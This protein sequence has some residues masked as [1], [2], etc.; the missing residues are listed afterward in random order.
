MPSGQRPAGTPIGRARR[1]C[2]R[3]STK[4]R[5][6]RNG[7]GRALRRPR[8]MSRRSGRTRRSTAGRGRPGAAQGGVAGG[9]MSWLSE[10][11]SEIRA[12]LA[13]V[14]AW[15]APCLEQARQWLT[16]P[17]EPLTWAALRAKLTLTT[18]PLPKTNGG[19]LAVLVGVGVLLLLALLWYASGQPDDKGVV[20]YPHASLINPI[21]GGLGALFLIY[22][23]IRQAGKSPLIGM[24]LKPMPISNGGPRRPSARQSSSSAARR[25][26]CGS[27]ASTR[28]SVSPGKPWPVLRGK[29]SGPDL[30]WTVMETLTAFVRERAR[31]KEPEPSAPEMAAQSDLWQSGS[32]SDQARQQP[33]TPATDIAAV[34]EVLRRRPDAGREREKLRDWRLDLTKTDLR[35][36]RLYE[37]HLE[38]ATSSRRI[39]KAPTSARRISKRADLSEA[40][41]E[42]AH[43]IGAHLERAVLI[44]AHLEGANLGG[45]HLEG[46]V[47]ESASSAG[48]SATP[49][50]SCRTASRGRPAGRPMRRSP[51]GPVSPAATGG[52]IV[53]DPRAVSR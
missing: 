43:L 26:R 37:A 18:L 52:K 12:R 44:R 23:A 24:Q 22:A 25:W 39:S 45:A 32:Q 9:V 15:A 46:A 41:L 31:W 50:P 51:R 6:R 29:A 35:G 16:A 8:T 3:C 49:K 33:P 4:P 7:P 5:R 42:G 27:A 28:W 19:R 30:Y 47:L 13:S 10:R 53:A 1:R 48:R 2:A 21:L 17:R 11:L 34:L 40:H 14:R 38:G 20:T 36:A